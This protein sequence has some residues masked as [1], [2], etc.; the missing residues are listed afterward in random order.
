MKLNKIEEP[1]YK[2]KFDQLIKAAKNDLIDMRQLLFEKK[3]K[4]VLAGK[5]MK[6]M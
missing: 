5:Q 6:D 1:S 4:Y 2:I 3:R